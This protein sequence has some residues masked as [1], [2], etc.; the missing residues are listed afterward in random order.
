MINVLEAVGRV[1]GNGFA[2]AGIFAVLIGTAALAPG[3]AG[4]EPWAVSAEGALLDRLGVLP[5]SSALV[6]S[7]GDA[8]EYVTRWQ[9]PADASGWAHRRPEVERALREAIGLV[10]LPDR[11]PLN[12]RSI[13]RYDFRGYTLETLVFESRPGF[14]VPAHLYRPQ[15]LGAVKHAAILS[16]IGHF[17]GAGKAAGQVQARCIGLA[18]LGFVVLTY[19]AIGQGERMAPGNVHHEAGYALLP[20]GETIAGWMV[21]DSMRAIDYLQSLPEV[22]PDRIGVTGNSGG[23][24]NTLYTAALDPRV[25]ACAIAGFCCEFSTWLKYGGIHCSCVHLP[26]LFRSMEWFEVAGLIA[27]R[28]VLILQ[29]EHDL[30]FPITGA[31]K[32]GHATE[33]LYQL[34]GRPERARFDEVPAEGHGYY[35]PYRERMYGWMSLQL[36]GKGEG[37]PIPE[38]ELQWLDEKDPRLLCDPGHSF[39]PRSPAVVECAR[40]KA[41]E[42]LSRREDKAGEADQVKCRQWVGDLVSAGPSGSNYLSPIVVQKRLVPGGRLEKLSFVSEDGQY[43]PGLFWLPANTN[44]PAQVLVM[45]NERGKAAVAESGLV[46]PLLDA[47]FAVFAVDLRGRGET[48]GYVGPR[49][50]TNFRLV[51]NQVLFGQPLTGRRAFDLRR[52]V[53]YLSLRP[54]VSTNGV[55]VLGFGN[56]AL[57][58][59][60]AAAADPRIR[61]VAV[62]GYFH[63]FV[64]QIAARVPAKTALPAQWNDPQLDG[65]I[66]TG[67]YDVDFASVIPGALQ[68]AD[69]YDLARLIAPRRLLFSGARDP[70]GLG[71]GSWVNQFKAAAEAPGEAWL[72]YMP[73]RPLRSQDLLHWLKER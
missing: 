7:L 35:K 38:G 4:P 26:G 11:A 40:A 22:D 68:V 60:L 65:V 2:V 31:R 25:K 62:S 72:L 49:F 1:R 55:A 54:E 16:P 70:Q 69:I 44:K 5:N 32:A 56:D 33:A 6:K 67:A 3:A 24:L 36:L 46:Q 27:P 41:L 63:S 51:A 52:A 23:G 10:K 64:S 61:Q 73:D 71:R 50:N 17:L 53:D 9:L 57:P 30:I 39:M 42:L 21:W 20:L 28:A 15:P 12:P 59:L 8:A 18:R 34:L 43:I 45:A 66:N 29:G 19:D 37:Q 48:L 47:G 58:V 14:Y 13:A